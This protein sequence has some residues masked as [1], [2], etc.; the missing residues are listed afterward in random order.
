VPTPDDSS[1]QT[2]W[3]PPQKYICSSTAQLPLQLPL[4]LLRVPVL[5]LSLPMLLAVAQPLL[6]LLLLDDGPTHRM[7]Q[8]SSP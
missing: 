3:R 8:D 7:R 4:L 6:W 1:K 5:L 2:S